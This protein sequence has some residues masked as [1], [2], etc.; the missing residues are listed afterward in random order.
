MFY[1]VYVI[2][3]RSL[4]S[5]VLVQIFQPNLNWSSKSQLKKCPP[6]ITLT[7]TAH[8]R[9]PSDETKMFIRGV[10]ISC[11]LKSVLGVRRSASMDSTFEVRTRISMVYTLT[12]NHVAKHGPTTPPPPWNDHNALSRHE[13]GVIRFSVRLSPPTPKQN[14]PFHIIKEIWIY[15]SRN[16]QNAPV[17]PRWLVMNLGEGV[18]HEKALWC[19]IEQIRVR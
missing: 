16:D 1:N 5:N 7:V 2:S 18:N 19:I 10:W 9:Q 8:S 4:N 15:I 6:S 17:A 3:Y 12:L 13:L 11:A 14:A